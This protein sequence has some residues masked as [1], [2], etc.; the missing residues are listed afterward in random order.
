MLGVGQ[1]YACRSDNS[2][3]G[4]RRAYSGSDDAIAKVSVSGQVVALG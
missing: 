2:E 4:Q 3:S 1:S